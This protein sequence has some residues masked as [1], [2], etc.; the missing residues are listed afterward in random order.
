MVQ[1]AEARIRRH[2]E[3][4]D[5]PRKAGRWEEPNEFEAKD[6]RLEALE[7]RFARYARRRQ[8]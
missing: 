5:E 1:T 3:R 2:L 6:R 4:L 8:A 7:R